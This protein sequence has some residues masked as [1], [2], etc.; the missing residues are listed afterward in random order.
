MHS[1]VLGAAP[2]FVIP[3]ARIGTYLS[4]FCIVLNREAKILGVTAFHN[5][6]ILLVLL[7]GLKPTE[8]DGDAD[9]CSKNRFTNNISTR[10]RS[11]SFSNVD[12]L[13][14]LFI[15][16]RSE[17]KLQTDKS[18]NLASASRAMEAFHFVSFI[19]YE[20]RLIELD[21]LKPFP[22]DHGK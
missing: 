22:M 6:K 8:V 9:L 19:A 13:K 18:K 17:L 20:G 7:Y 10:P 21:G 15:I 11:I 12:T 14:I 5:F 1:Y 3:T 16:F 2:C 4:L